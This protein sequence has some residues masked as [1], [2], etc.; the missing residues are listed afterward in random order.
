MKQLFLFVLFFIASQMVFSQYTNGGMEK[1]NNEQSSKMEKKRFDNPFYL[2]LGASLPLG[3]FGGNVS[4][5][6][7]IT[8]SFQ[9]LDNMSAKTG[10]M[11]EVGT[12]FYLGL[13]LQ[14]QFKVGIDIAYLDFSINPVNWDNAGTDWASGDMYL[15]PFVFIGQ[16]YGVAF[17]YNPIGALILDVSL[18]IGP[19]LTIPSELED[20]RGNYSNNEELSY[21]YFISTDINMMLKKSVGL[22][23]RFHALIV[24]WEF[25]WGRINTTGSYSFLNINNYTVHRVEFNCLMPTSSNRFTIGVKF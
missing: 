14:E 22:N 15:S 5:V 12:I 11:L 10:P 8:S 3:K 4:P 21:N 9:G 16:K 7:S 25:N 13:P 23:F 1:S 18:K 20:R 2:R 17:S 24:G 19:T 6:K